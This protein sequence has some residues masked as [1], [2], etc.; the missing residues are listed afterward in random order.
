[1]RFLHTADWHVG[2]TLRGR[3]RMDELA[4]ALDEIVALARDAG[5][6]GVLVAGDVYD[7]AAPSPDAERLVYETLAR[8]RDAGVPCVV[9]AGNHD[10]P[11]RLAAIAPLA[12][13]LRLHIRTDLQG[14]RDGGIVMLPSRDGDQAAKILALP[15]IPERRAA[16][17]AAL[18]RPSGPAPRGY[19]RTVEQAIAA[20]AR[21][22]KA[23]TVNI[24]LGHALVTGGQ[25]GTGERPLHLTDTYS[26]SLQN[27]PKRIQYVALGHLHRPQE[28][29]AP[30]RAAYSGSLIELDFGERQQEKRVILVEA[31][32]G[33]PPR[34]ESIPLRSGRAL[35][36]VEGTFDEVLALASEIG[37]AY[38]R[39]RIK[40]DGP[41]PSLADRVREALPLAV[42][43]RLAL[44]RP[45]STDSAPAATPSLSPV[46]L[47]ERFHARRY[48][49]PPTPDVL[50]LF[51]RLHE[52]AQM[53]TE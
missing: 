12:E 48:D 50:A 29:L 11:R 17:A 21:G 16:D 3:S 31:N 9:I 36:D 25:T 43:V 20:L 40:T 45:T 38:L 23:E 51:R 24:L 19:A 6:D 1:M 42:D 5:V 2:K 13:S 26:I 46:E 37:D 34:L 53:G 52:E 27:V 4:G 41:Q 10:H 14:A 30:V 7:N 32:P 15:F 35:R 8:L 33:A 18:M 49:A 39:V 47:F 44:T 28:L 22:I